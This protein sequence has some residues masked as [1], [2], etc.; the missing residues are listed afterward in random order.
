VVAYAHH[1]PGDDVHSPS[2]KWQ[3]NGGL[4]WCVVIVAAPEV[5]SCT[6][7][8]V[9]LIWMPGCEPESRTRDRLGPVLCRRAA[10]EVTPGPSLDCLCSWC[11]SL[12]VP[13]DPRQERMF[14][15]GRRL[16]QLGP[17]VSQT[18][19]SPTC[20]QSTISPC[21]RVFNFASQ[22]ARLPIHFGGRTWPWLAHKRVLC[23]FSSHSF[24]AAD[25]QHAG[26]IKMSVDWN[27]GFC[28]VMDA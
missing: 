11:P 12:D 15:S 14:F 7:G 8:I 13:L 28:V 16:D 1:R 19:A 20:L 2:A 27:M 21:A 5:G 18:C 24:D 25:Y 4:F 17:K 10:R 3:E 9:A 23:A 22:V 6:S 26:H